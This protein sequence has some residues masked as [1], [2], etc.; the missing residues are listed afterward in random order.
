M[1][2]RITNLCTAVGRVC[3][4]RWTRPTAC[5]ST[6]RSR[7][8]SERKTCCASTREMPLA[9]DLSGRSST[10]TLGSFRKL[11]SAASS[12]PAPCSRR[13]GTSFSLSARAMSESMSSHCE[14]MRH[15]SPAGSAC[16]C[17]T[18]AVTLVPHEPLTLVPAEEPSAHRSSLAIASGPFSRQMG[19]TKLPPCRATMRSAQGVHSECA[20]RAIERSFGPTSSWQT[21]HMAMAAPSP[22]S[23]SASS[24]CRRRYEYW[25]LPAL[26]S[27]IARARSPRYLCARSACSYL[28]TYLCRSASSGLI[29][30]SSSSSSTSSIVLTPWPSSSSCERRS[31]CADQRARHALI[32]RFSAASSSS[33]RDASA[34]SALQ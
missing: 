14:K 15:L 22:P 24:A 31:K 19:Q 8:G 28:T 32:S 33:S 17:S 6:A 9:P 1:V 29:L 18:I 13:K 2:P 16:T 11:W 30:R 21:G 3:D 27:A 26:R 23:P 5:A 20:Q 12:V 34:Q 25:R 7:S 10:R 4:M